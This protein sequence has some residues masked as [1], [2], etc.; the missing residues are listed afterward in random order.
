MTRRSLRERGER[1]PLSPEN[2]NTFK[3]TSVA[4]PGTEKERLLAILDGET[5]D[6]AAVI[7]P[8]G[9]MNAATTAVLTKIGKN[10]HAD[11]RAMAEAAAEVRRST[12]FE[13]FGAPFCMTAEAECLRSRVDLGSEVV[14]PCVAEYGLR[15][16]AE[17]AELAL[18]DPGR[19]GRLPVILEALSILARQDGGGVPVIGN[20]TGPISLATSALDPLL[21]F[22]LMG[23]DPK[24]VHLFLEFVSEFLVEFARAQISA[25]ADVISIADPSATG[26]ILGRSLFHEFAAP[27]LARLVGA[28]RQTGARAI[29]HIC[30]DT[31]LLFEELNGIHGTAF[32]FDSVV[33]MKKARTK[34]VGAPLMGNLNT[35]LLHQSTPER[36]TKA[37][38]RLIE[39]KVEIISPAC[40]LSMQTPLENLKAMTD[41]AKAPEAYAAPAG[42]E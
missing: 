40:G 27:Y 4:M 16:L 22:R 15:S 14:E 30:G 26:E 33:S 20:L 11:S 32:S 38:G 2:S 18:P 21:F 35:Q 3:T 17:A 6:R 9:M 7:C 36:V 19:D 34:I 37:V 39:Q 41:T 13:N 10:V 25:G 42:V 23:K 12:G 29:L 31:S 24:G 5:V 28:I 1:F 8:G